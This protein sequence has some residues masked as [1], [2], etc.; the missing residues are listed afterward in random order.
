MTEDEKEHSLFPEHEMLRVLEGVSG[1]VRVKL[2]YSPRTFYGKNAPH[3][4]DRQKLGIHFSW[5]GHIY[6]LLST[7]EPHQIRIPDVQQHTAISEF[8]VKAGERLIFSLCYSSQNPAV[9]P[10]LKS[11]GWKRMEHTIRFWRNWIGKCHYSGLYLEA[12][13][14]KRSCAQ[15]FRLCTFRSHHCSPYH[16]PA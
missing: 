6:T 14:A 5:K 13:S 10:E 4:E 7:L 9:L 12:G 3:L 16:L 15:A 2:H 8:S 1:T 11:T